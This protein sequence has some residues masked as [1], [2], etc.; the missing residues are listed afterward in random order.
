[1]AVR[2]GAEYLAGLRDTREVWLDGARIADVTAHPALAPAA[3]AIAMHYDAA[4][5]DERADL[6]TYVEPSTGERCNAA[7]LLPR[8][9]AELV[10]RRVVS[11]YYA[12]LSGGMIGRP[13][14]FLGLML[15]HMLRLKDG[16]AYGNSTYAANLERYFAECRDG[17]RCVAHTF[18]DPLGDRSRPLAEWPM[19]RIIDECADGVVVHGVKSMATLAP[20]ADELLVFPA[21]RSGLPPEAVLYFAV[22]IATPGLRL[23]CREPQASEG[24]HF[25]HP[26]RSRFD[27]MDA[28]VVFDHVLV[29]HTRIFGRGAPER[30]V[31]LFDRLMAPLN[32]ALVRVAAKAELI[33]GVAAQLA[34]AV[35]TFDQPDTQQRL[36]VIAHFRETI[37]AYL[38]AADARGHPDANGWWVPHARTITA[39]KV[40]AVAHYQD[41][42]TAVQEIGGQGLIA[43]PQERDFGVAALEPFL[44]PTFRAAASSAAERTRLFKLAWDIVGDGFGG[45]QLLFELFSGRGASTPAALM[46]GYDTTTAEALARQLAGLDS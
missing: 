25:D 44:E 31:P 12:R 43:A 18:T 33:L 8:S 10:R 3:R 2:S 4:R 7:F 11:E 24:R 45:R 28:L 30:V 1:M 13:P 27:E 16:F 29:P 39:G 40:Y 15:A 22:P 6:L 9:H 36:A 17:D 21:P 41:L 42:L 32:H 26:L 35:G 37:Q 38:V 34:R 46:R 5:G 14:D 23:L 19:V 20:Q